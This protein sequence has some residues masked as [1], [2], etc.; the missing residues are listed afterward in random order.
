MK[1]GIKQ[2]G[3]AICYYLLFLGMQVIVSVFYGIGIGVYAAMNGL[4][5]D[6]AATEMLLENQT[7]IVMISGLL[8]IVFLMIFFAIRK[9]KWHCEANCNRI[10]IQVIA[11]LVTLAIG[12]Y[13]F[14]D[15]VLSLLPESL[16]AD[17]VQTSEAL[18]GKFSFVQLVATALIVPFVEEIFFRGL[19]LSRLQ[20]GMPHVAAVVLTSLLFG[21]AHGQSIWIAYAFLLGCV[22]A[23]IAHQTQSITSSMIIHMIFNLLGTTI[24]FLLEQMNL[25]ND[26]PVSVFVGSVIMGIAMLICSWYWLRN[27]QNQ[28]EEKGLVAE[29]KL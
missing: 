19:I 29:G 8:G 6:Q 28:M 3:K 21:I 11:P 10:P 1:T 27:I 14:I 22:L 26:I 5:S 15:G 24:P 20:K 25:Q 23:V 17:Y 7:Q 13:L 4:T 9:K 16:I 12:L 18:L 2:F